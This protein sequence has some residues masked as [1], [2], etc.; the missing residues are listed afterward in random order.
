MT[1]VEDWRR[2]L[3]RAWSIRFNLAAAAL[4]GAIAAWPALM[5][6]IPDDTFIWGAVA[7]NVGAMV[8]R[9]LQ[10]PELSNG[11]K[12]EPPKQ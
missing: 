10:Q 11:T 8:A 6:D 5:N 1:L 9:L 12:Q 4:T 7:L 2:I 3:R